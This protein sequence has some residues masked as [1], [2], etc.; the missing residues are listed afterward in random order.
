MNARTPLLVV[1][2]TLFAGLS[3]ACGGLEEQMNELAAQGEIVM[4]EGESFGAGTDQAGCMS[5]SMDR[6]EACTGG[7]MEKGTCQGMAQVYLQGC[8]NN[9][10]ATAGFCDGA[11][12]KEEIMDTVNW[13]IAKCE[14]AGRG[15]EQSCPNM[16]QT[17][18][19][20]CNQG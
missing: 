16:Q 20:W 8:L 12:A 3:L 13:G 14:E 10:A 4:A 2:A 9:A 7:V 11:P 19:E 1:A 18:A 17:R 6:A 5:A 15:G